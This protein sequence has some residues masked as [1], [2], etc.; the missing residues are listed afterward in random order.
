MNWSTDLSLKFLALSIMQSDCIA[1]EGLEAANYCV[2]YVTTGKWYFFSVVALRPRYIKKY[3]TG[4]IVQING[5]IKPK[6]IGSLI[7]SS[8]AWQGIDRD[9][10]YSRDVNSLTG[11]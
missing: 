3:A 7:Q 9:E 8:M 6:A 1:S 11:F 5:R 10:L 2:T 4:F